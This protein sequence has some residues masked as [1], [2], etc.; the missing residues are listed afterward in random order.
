MS[1][2]ESEPG[3]RPWTR[4]PIT[5]VLATLFAVSAVWFAVLYHRGVA[6]DSLDMEFAKS[7]LNVGIVS[8]AA[9]VLSLLVF[10]HQRQVEREERAR[11][12]RLEANQAAAESERARLTYRD[13]L[14]TR[15]LS[16]ITNAYNNTKR[17]RRRMRALGRRV[18]LLGDS[19]LLREYDACMAE[20][21]DAQLDLEAIKS[22]VKTGRGAYPSAEA[23]LSSLKAMESYLGSLLE[24]YEQER[25]KSMELDSEAPLSKLPRLGD[26]L[27]PSKGSKFAR[28]FSDQ[29][30]AVRAAIRGDLLHLRLNPENSLIVSR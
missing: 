15:T 21:N 29:H 28:D 1:T 18:S 6:K 4:A 3:K 17:S 14:L 9:T 26:F 20:V 7:L 5:W 12:L 10:G 16:R 13:D 8:V 19:I 30:A 23:L 2:V 24:E 27:G 25:A 22:D 11:E